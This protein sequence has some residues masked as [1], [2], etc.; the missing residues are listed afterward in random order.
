MLSMA[1]AAFAVARIAPSSTPSPALTP[2]PFQY[3]TMTTFTAVKYAVL[4]GRRSSKAALG[5]SVLKMGGLA[6]HGHSRR[7]VVR[8]EHAGCQMLGLHDGAAN[9]VAVWRIDR[10]KLVRVAHVR[11]L[12]HV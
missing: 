9:L 11:D 12:S 6:E 5:L 2:V 8:L 10:L 3:W 4:S 7:P 1:A